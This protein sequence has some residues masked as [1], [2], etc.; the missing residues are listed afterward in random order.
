M[1]RQGASLVSNKWARWVSDIAIFFLLNLFVS[2][3]YYIMCLQC[4]R[5][6]YKLPLHITVC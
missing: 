5:P 1:L 6:G 4:C 2:V 3:V